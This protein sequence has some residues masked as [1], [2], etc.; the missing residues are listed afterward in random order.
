MHLVRLAPNSKVPVKGE[1]QI[2]DDPQVHAEWLRSGSNV[3][4]RLE[5]NGRVVV[6]FDKDIQ[7]AR[8]HYRQALC[9]VIVLSKRGPH[10]HYSGTDQTRKFEHGDIKANGHVL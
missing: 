8:E 1:L 9:Q 5:E 3:G 6:D 2:S 7:A 10:F 4:F